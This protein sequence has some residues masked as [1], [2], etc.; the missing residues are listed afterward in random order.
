MIKQS[1]LWLN[2]TYDKNDI[3]YLVKLYKFC[4]ER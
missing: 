2:S 3:I 1:I 4:T